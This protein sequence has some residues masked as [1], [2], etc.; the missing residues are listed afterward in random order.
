LKSAL[1]N[2]TWADRV[3]LI[4]LIA[5]SAGGMLYAR[6]AL[7]LG[8]DVVIEAG[9]KPIYTLPLDADR[10]I[11]VNGSHG[12]AVVEIKDGKVRMKEAECENHICVKQGWISHG[13]IVCLPNNIVVTVGGG[14]SKDI[15]AV[16]G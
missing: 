10:L 7:S 16:T 5:A 4:C 1:K 11:A 12:R 3:L 2:T 6:D 8:S 15:D 13:V 9:G 14:R